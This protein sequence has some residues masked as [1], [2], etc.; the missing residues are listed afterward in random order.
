MARL[1]EEQRD[2]Y[3]RQLMLDEIDTTGQGA[4]LDAKVLVV[5]AGG[6]GS[7][8]IQ[9]L[10][11]AGVGHLGIVDSGLVERSNLQRQLIHSEAMIGEPKVESAAEFV[12]RLNRDVHVEAIQESLEAENVGSL[13]SPYDVVVDGLDGFEAR[14]LL[15]EAARDRDIPFVHGAVHG[16]VGQMIVFTPGGPCYHCLYPERPTAIPSGDPVEIFPVVPGAIGCMEAAET[17]KYLLEVG[18]V[19]N[20]HLL[21]FDALASTWFET[22]VRPDPACPVCGGSSTCSEH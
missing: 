10:T 12:N 14:Y 4:L 7:P 5:G 22:P 6:L 3:S 17:L 16:F 1:T 8:V 11:A 18:E 9:Y 19:R 21:R 2:R 15:N 20:D 13:I